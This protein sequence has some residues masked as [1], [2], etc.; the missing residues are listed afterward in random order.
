MWQ[1]IVEGRETQQRS[2]L[3]LE[4]GRS[5]WVGRDRDC[6]IPV[7]WESLLS[8]KHVQLQ[9]QA[10]EVRAQV[11]RQSHNP[12]FVNGESQSEFTLNSGDRFVVGNTSFTLRELQML[13]PQPDA[14]VQEVTFSRAELAS[15]R[16]EDADRRLEALARLPAVIAASQDAEQRGSH[17]AS[18]ILSGIRHAEAAAVVHCDKQGQ[19]TVT[20]WERRTETRGAFKPSLG[21]VTDSL[22]Q[23]RTILHVWEKSSPQLDGYTVQA[24]FD[25]AVCTPV[26][27]TAQGVWGIYVAGKL[28][29]P[30]S[31]QHPLQRNLQ[32]DVRF[33]QLVGEVLGSAEQ[34][35]LMEG[36]LSILRQFL[37]P[38]ILA[39]LE[40]TGRPGSLNIDLLQ[41]KVCDVTVI[42]CDLRG[43]SQKVEEESA[44][45]KG[46]LTRVNGALE[47]MT[48]AILKHGGV[49]GEFL[50]DAVLGFWGWPFPSED[51]PLKAC[52]A[53]LEV[54]TQ[55]ARIQK[56]AQHPLQ[57]FKV[58]VGV[59]HGRAV[60]GKV[61][62]GGRISVSV[63][64]PVVNLASRLEG[65][66]KRLRV[67]VILDEATAAIARQRLS[68]DEGRVRTLAT[69]LPYGLE[70]PLTVSEL[71]P[72]QGE[73]SELTAQELAMFEKGVREFREGRWD[74]A[75]KALHGMPSS[76]EAQDFLLAMIAQHSRSAPG[77]WKGIVE[78]PSK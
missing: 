64:G 74:A 75:Y 15:V 71:I 41:P 42:F 45:L 7:L 73:F 21:L 67:P 43:F 32:S 62:T 48:A 47:V 26:A 35:N 3:R 19:V 5:Y 12:V 9:A 50:G 38:P 70:T 61:G 23:D 17:L 8:R 4:P 52:R 66:T 1:L 77:S 57:D 27:K 10:T 58:G 30:L 33:A 11:S 28:D 69:V 76:D 46:L 13:S 36:Q 34:R 56:T 49:T 29:Q 44:N 39:A 18:L 78:L 2:K 6:D 59:A 40:E 14:P 68:A 72:P 20:A 16:F 63:F 65:L 51:A 31:E 55:F 60:A 53:A 37:S 25:W 22:Q 54:R 24:E